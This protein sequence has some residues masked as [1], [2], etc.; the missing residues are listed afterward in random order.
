MTYP[1]IRPR[2]LRYTHNR[3]TLVQQHHLHAKD[4]IQPFFI[5]EGTNQIQEIP[6]LPNIYR[7]S[8]DTLLPKVEK[9]VQ[10][11]IQAIALFPVLNSS[12]KDHQGTQ[13]LNPDNLICRSVR[14]LKQ[15]FPDLLLIT[16]VALDPYTVHGHDGLLDEQGMMDN[17]QTLQVLGQQ[18]LLQAKAGA[19]ILAPSDMCDG[20]IGHIRRLLETEGYPHTLI[21]SY[22]IK[23][24][25]SLY[26]PFRQAVQSTQSQG[27]DKKN[28]QMDYQTSHDILQEIQL[29]VNEG[30]DLAIIKPSLFYLDVIAKISQEVDIPLFAYQVSGEYN[31][32]YHA[33]SGDGMDRKKILHENFIAYK[34]SGCTGIITYFAIEF[35]EKYA[36]PS[37]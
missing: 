32:L 3:R 6:A 26:S 7:Y 2:R 12:L 23:Y 36:T 15:H 29:D 17:D 20:R 10:L 28:Y 5:V 16:D 33:T 21:M 1:L 13:A 27:I 9:C 35:L 24:A 18:A 22:A 31:M 30:A 4:F 34:R 14:L 11:G 37:D 25:S 8:L 19:D